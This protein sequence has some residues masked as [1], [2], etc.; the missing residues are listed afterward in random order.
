M[1]EYRLGCNEIGRNVT[2]VRQLAAVVVVYNVF[3]GDS[4]TCQAL[5]QM[6]DEHLNVIIYDNSTKDYENRQFCETHGWDYLGGTGN[7][8]L[9]VAYNACIDHVKAR[10]D[11]CL[12]CL[13]D[14]DTKISAD[15]FQL[16]QAAAS[17]CTERI[18]VPLIYSGGN[19]MSPCILKPG[20]HIG[21]FDS[22]AVALDYAGNDL[23]AINSCMALDIRIFDDYR[24]DE[25]IFLDGIDHKFLRDMKARGE[26]IKVFPY[27][28]D[29]AFS[30][31]E[32][33]PKE[34]ALF[35]FRLFKKDFQYILR[36]ERKTYLFLVGKRALKLTL[37][38]KTL[39]FIKAMIK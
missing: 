17:E 25:Q 26:R 1:P 37:Q 36:E 22:D 5:M 12:L 9:S 19:L 20:Y 11:G 35:R 31:D 4:E 23:S 29:H 30:G 6:Q 2:D 15:Y 32:L 16:L 28:C 38:Y 39:D 8:G 10:L 27:R 24:Y 18:F 3:C 13:F 34:S 7:R 14:D 33:P 21:K